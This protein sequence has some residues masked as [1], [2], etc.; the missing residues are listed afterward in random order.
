MHLTYTES[1]GLPVCLAAAACAVQ[2]TPALHASQR[3]SLQHGRACAH[4]PS[5]A[6]LVDAVLTVVKGGFFKPG[7]SVR[8]ARS[9]T[10]NLLNFCAGPAGG[11][12]QAL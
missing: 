2:G 12:C 8:P 11:D 3:A 5:L 10:D 6:Q 1:Q 9:C 4:V 7:A